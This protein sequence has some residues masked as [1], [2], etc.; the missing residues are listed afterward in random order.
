M[1]DF[2]QPKL[3]EEFLFYCNVE[4]GLSKNTIQAYKTDL[5]QFI[6][7]VENDNVN[8]QSA[9]EYIA[10]LN[11]KPNTIKR[12]YM[13]LRSFFLFLIEVKRELDQYEL[14]KLEP[15]SGEYVS[16]K[17]IKISE[18]NDI[19]TNTYC[20]LDKILIEL[21][22]STGLRVSEVCSLKKDS[23]LWKKGLCRF[24][25]KGNAERIV[26]IGKICLIL[27][28]DYLSLRQDQRDDL[29]VRENGE[30]I[31]RF[32]IYRQIHQYGNVSPHQL[33]HSFATHLLDNNASLETIQNLLGHASINTTQCYLSVSDERKR[34]VYQEY[35]LGV[36]N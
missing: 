15:V 18:I 4:L 5:Y 6:N 9:N 8:S 25:G 11:L 29:L 28:Q 35:F 20:L 26:P 36:K 19:S 1:A 17:P 10:S 7:F 12:K 24:I 34:K 22:Y 14:I 30:P 3:V 23:I 27:L 2:K 31:N 32:F 13:A 16:P 21:I 33:R